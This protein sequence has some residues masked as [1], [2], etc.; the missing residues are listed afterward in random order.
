MNVDEIKEANLSETAEGYTGTRKFTV[1]D[2]PQ[3]PNAPLSAVYDDPRIPIVGAPYGRFGIQV[4]KRS[5]DSDASLVNGAIVTVE[6]GVPDSSQDVSSGKASKERIEL[7]VGT[8]TERTATDIN[9]DFLNVSYQGSESSF[10]KLAQVQTAEVQRPVFRFTVRRDEQAI[11]FQK[12][13]DFFGKVNS[14]QFFGFASKTLLLLG[15]A[16]A[17]TNKGLTQE[18]AYE[19]VF[20]PDTWRHQARLLIGG[21]LPTDATL[22]NGI[23]VYDVFE[24]I[25]FAGLGI[26]LNV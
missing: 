10:L 1:T 2:I 26:S 14:T 13:L 24:S 3:T 12:A 5:A 23:E 16:N 25:D 6:Y 8:I 11:P 15:L 7:K 20:K 17:D 19:I 22:G 9:G 4:L 21:R 18:V